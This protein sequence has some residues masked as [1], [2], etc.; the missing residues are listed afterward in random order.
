MFKAQRRQPMSFTYDGE[1]HLTGCFRA[2]PPCSHQY[3][4]RGRRD[5][6]SVRRRGQISPTTL[7]RDLENEP[8]TVVSVDARQFA[9]VVTLDVGWSGRGGWCVVVL[10]GEPWCPV[11]FRL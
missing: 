11:I 9:A 2:V 5:A 4:R 6:R 1:N 10:D 3:L 7:G 8:M